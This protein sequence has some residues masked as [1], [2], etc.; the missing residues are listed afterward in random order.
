MTDMDESKSG[1]AIST[2]FALIILLATLPPAAHATVL[3]FSCPQTV[4]PTELT[5][6]P[7]KAWQVQLSRQVSISKHPVRIREVQVIHGEPV[8]G[9]V[10]GIL[11]PSNA[12]SRNGNEP[13]VWELDGDNDVWISCEYEGVS[14]VRALTGSIRACYAQYRNTPFRVARF[15]CVRD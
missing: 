12:G 5:R 7:H 15:W 4:V 2:S 9:E 1:M 11:M 10:R 13:F 8:A 6:N 14:L 3:E